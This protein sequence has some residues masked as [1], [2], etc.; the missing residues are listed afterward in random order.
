MTETTAASQQDL[1]KIDLA[2]IRVRLAAMRAEFKA[3]GS[4]RDILDL[5][6][7]DA[8]LQRIARGVYGSCESC[9]RPMP[10]ARLLAAPQSRYCAPCSEGELHAPSLTQSRPKL[11]A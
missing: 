8:A 3:R 1:S 9:A 4:Q 11:Y 2:K 10:K 5:Q 6:R 7:V